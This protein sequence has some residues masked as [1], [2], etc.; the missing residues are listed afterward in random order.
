MKYDY[1]IVGAGPF[2]AAFAR[3]ASDAGQSCLVI[4]RRSHLA[5][6]TYTQEIAGVLVHMYGAHIFHTDNEAIWRFVNQFGRWQ[7]FHNS[8]RI[9]V[10]D[11]IFS[12][13]INL[14]TLHQLWGIATPDEAR[15][16]LDQ[17]R[18]PC[19]HP[20]N[21][22]EWLLSQV[23]RQLYELFFLGYTKKHWSR[24]PR[25]LPASIVQRLPIR[26][27]YN[28]N[29]FDTKYQAIPV[30]GYT[31]VFARMLDGIP[32]ELETDFFALDWRR[33]ARH[34]VFTGRIDQFFGFEFGRLEYRSLRFDFQVFDRDFQG[35]AVF[36]YPDESVPYLRTI[37]HKYFLDSGP[38]HLGPRA[39]SQSVVTFDC[40]LPPECEATIS[41]PQYPV[42]DEANLARL[43]EYQVAARKCPQV[44]FG[45]RLG[46]YRYYDIDQAIASAI[47]KASRLCS[48]ELS[49]APVTGAA[50]DDASDRRQPSQSGAF[51]AAD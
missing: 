51:G 45:G 42:R 10:G 16:R 6:N 1:L 27:T 4:D 18:V 25:D 49:T 44:I 41:D 39:S 24:H 13:P 37:E 3:T 12:F 38:K 19:D 35:H 43:K 20:Q 9:R 36:N 17:E 7:P 32:V 28:D 34:L 14:L 21:A 31:G 8:P 29:Y 46:E 5:G 30:D 2:G 50:G 23:G 48:T 11:R 26:L 22:E 33:F 47:Q 15:A 40:P